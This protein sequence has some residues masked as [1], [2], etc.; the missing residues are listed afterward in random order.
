MVCMELPADPSLALE[1]TELEIAEMEAAASAP[2]AGSDAMARNAG[3]LALG[4]VGSRVLGLLRESVIAAAF[5]A[6][7]QVSAYRVAAQVPT[8][9]YD[10]LVGGMLSAA[11]VPVLSQSAE[12]GTHR[13]SEFVR[14]S[15]TLLG[16]FGAVL[17]VLMVL[18]FAVAPM[19]ARL[20]AAGFGAANPE[21][22]TLTANLIRLMAPAVWFFGVAGLL[23]AILYALQRFSFPALAV[24]IF[25][26]GVVISVPLLAGRIGIG[27]AAVGVLVGSLAQMSIMAWDVRRAGVP[28]LPRFAWRHPALRRILRLYLPI[29]AGM[30]VALFQVGLDRRLASGTGEQ[31]IAWMAAATTLQQMP[32]GLISVAISLAALPTLSRHFAALNEA[33]FAATLGRGLRF[34]LLLILPAAV[35]LSLLAT[36]VTRLLFER[37]A[38]T[39]ADT[40]AVVAALQIY[41]VGMLFAAVDFPLNFAFYARNNTLLPA[42]V[43]V[44][45]VGVYVIVAFALLQPMGYRGLVWADTAK[46][47]AHAAIMFFFAARVVQRPSGRALLARLGPLLLGAGFM[48]AVIALVDALVRPMAP[49]SALG[50]IMRVALAG[51]AGAAAYTTVLL[52]FQVE[53]ARQVLRKLRIRI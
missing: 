51:G 17:L 41:L 3:L 28:L 35:G 32:L 34:V 46:Q 9:I 43:G 12:Q 8:L 16:V 15:R 27:A 20:L 33:A 2:A 5:G 44:A 39:P 42:L 7:G 21:L 10:L 23:T 40:S 47:A 49:V 25:N 30:V 50:D 24:A 38:F 31:S 6:S 22:L 18:L 11:L 37:G 45:S 53:E 26:L 48:A 19:L 1:P 36:P 4:S 52:I 29:A 14:L 13:K